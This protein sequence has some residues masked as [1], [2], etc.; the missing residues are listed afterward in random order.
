[1]LNASVETT[2]ISIETST[3][4]L[5]SMNDALVYVDQDEHGF[6]RRRVGRSFAYYDESGKLIR[7]AATLKRIR[8][9]AI[10]PAYENV[11]IS[12]TPEGHIQ[13]TGRDGRGRKQYRYHKL[14]SE[15]AGAAKFER[16]TS[17]ARG[18]PTL[19]ERIAA[20]LRGPGL[21]RR[22]I[23]ATVVCLLETTLIRVGND[24]YARQN[25][26]FGLTTLFGR[27]VLVEGA[28]LRFEF[29]GK[30]GKLWRLSV[31]DRR[32][33]RIIRQCQELPGQRLFQ[34]VDEHGARLAITS[35]DVNAYLRELSGCEITAKDFRTWA[36]TWRAATALAEAGSYENPTQAKRILK[37]VI[38]DIAARLGNTPT[39]CRKS[40]VHPE[41]VAAFLQRELKLRAVQAASCGAYDLTPEEKS[42]LAF[43]RR[44]ASRES[45]PPIDRRSGS[46]DQSGLRA[47]T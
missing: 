43:L 1:M 47:T 25:K 2:S 33:A 36:G 9:L 6:R 40:Y 10:P 21:S 39:V 38:A 41:I 28:K 15:M 22:R 8:A 12:P 35:A 23:L 7:D 24:E 34:Y 44:L 13:A 3:F 20:D 16:M 32:I 17:F 18:L 30:S 46:C 31:T 29:K 45:P 19:R 5:A 4:P 27:H 42:V 14:W 11:W 37:G 26:S